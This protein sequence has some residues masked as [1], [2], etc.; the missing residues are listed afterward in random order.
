MAVNGFLPYTS[1]QC[2]IFSISAGIF[3]IVTVTCI[4]NGRINARDLIYG[5]VAGGI[6]GG[7]PS[8]FTTN[9]VYALV[10]GYTAGLFQAIFQS[11]FERNYLKKN[12]PIATISIPLFLFQ[13]LLGSAFAAGWKKITNQ[14]SNGQALVPTG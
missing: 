3:G 9:I 12:G 7:A 10:V 8:F 4:L 2:V 5:A 1:V 6:A 14:Y 13:G 11:I